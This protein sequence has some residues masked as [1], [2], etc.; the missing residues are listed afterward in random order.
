MWGFCWSLWGIRRFSGEFG[1]LV[2]K[3]DVK[4]Y[5]HKLFVAENVLNMLRIV[6]GIPIYPVYSTVYR[7]HSTVYI[8]FNGT[9]H[10]SN[11]SRAFTGKLQFWGNFR[12]FSAK[13]C[14]GFFV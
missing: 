7:Y 6:L 2:V 10:H 1:K 5:K 12:G 3:E 13:N 4:Y 11:E 9:L 8:F 14:R